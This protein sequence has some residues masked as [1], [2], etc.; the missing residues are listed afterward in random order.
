[1]SGSSA[2]TATIDTGDSGRSGNCTQ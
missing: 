1:V 2:L